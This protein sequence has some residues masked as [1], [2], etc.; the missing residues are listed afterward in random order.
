[1]WCWTRWLPMAP[2]RLSQ[3][4]ETTELPEGL[5][6]QASVLS[7]NYAFGDGS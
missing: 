1:M 7:L 3:C 6:E 5:T 2:Y 4:V